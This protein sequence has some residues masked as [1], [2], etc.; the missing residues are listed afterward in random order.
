MAL[1]DLLFVYRFYDREGREVDIIFNKDLAENL[2]DM[3]QDVVGD[4]T[5]LDDI[6]VVT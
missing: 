3:S 1:S 5:G 6:V 2:W 4:T